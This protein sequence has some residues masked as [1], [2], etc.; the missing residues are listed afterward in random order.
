MFDKNNKQIYNIWTK[1]EIK[2]VYLNDYSIKELTNNYNTRQMINKHNNSKLAGK[3]LDNFNIKA[4]FETN[5]NIY[6]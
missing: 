6:N 3:F 5:D 2:M 4:P 1:G